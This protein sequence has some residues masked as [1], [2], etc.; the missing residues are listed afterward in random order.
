MTRQCRMRAFATNGKSTAKDMPST[1][2]QNLFGGP[3]VNRQ[4]NPHRRHPQAR[5][6]RIHRQHTQVL[7][8]FRGF[9]VWRETPRIA[10]LKTPQPFIPLLC[11][12]KLL[13]ALIHRHL[14]YRRRVL[15]SNPHLVSVVQ[16][17]QDHGNQQHNYSHDDKDRR[18]YRR[19]AW[20]GGR[21]GCPIGRT[22]LRWFRAYP[23]H[24]RPPRIVVE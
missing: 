16:L 18:Q 6:H 10:Q 13:L 4:V 19:A 2:C 23:H 17:G 1:L 7:L 3:V 15:F 21:P 5:H 22:M 9:R 20:R 11:A 14:A 24:V 8:V 12:G